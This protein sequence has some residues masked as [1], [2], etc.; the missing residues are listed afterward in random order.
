[1]D[2]LCRANA[3]AES[4]AGQGI[5]FGQGA[6]QQDIVSFDCQRHRVVFPGRVNEIHV[7]FIDQQKTIKVCCDLGQRR[8]GQQFARWGMR[9]DQDAHFGPAS[10]SCWTKFSGRS[11]VSSSVISCSGLA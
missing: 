11:Q 6:Q 7:G 3:V 10:E 1:M 5:A 4:Q 9:I 8:N 2:Q